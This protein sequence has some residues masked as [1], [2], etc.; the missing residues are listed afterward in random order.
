MPENTPLPPT[1]YRRTRRHADRQF[2]WLVIGVLFLVGGGLIYAI[3]GRWAV[4]TALFC[5]VPGALL[6]L[7]LWGLLS[8]IERWLGE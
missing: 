8:L 5:L 3:Y 1:D 4:L 7:L 6:I 2:L